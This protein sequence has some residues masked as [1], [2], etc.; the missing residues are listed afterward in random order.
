MNKNM[1]HRKQKLSPS[2]KV[3]R[4]DD[5]ERYLCAQFAPRKFRDAL[6]TLLAFNQE[7]GRIPELVSEPALGQ[8]RLQWWCDAVEGIY[9]GRIAD[10]PVVQSLAAVVRGHDLP[11]ALFDVYLEARSMDVERRIPDTLEELERYALQTSGAITRLQVYVLGG[12]GAAVQDVAQNVGCAWGLIGLMR[13][14]PFHGSQ[15]RDYRPTALDPAHVVE[16]IVRR[17][18]ELIADARRHRGEVPKG[19][20]SALLPCLF[21]DS[22]IKRLQRADFDPYALDETKPRPGASLRMMLHGVIGRY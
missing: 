15:D 13:A 5:R 17:A 20:V 21:A 3:A 16:I 19:C 12:Q 7:V 6:Y 2:A 9:D 1:P 4:D 14:V 11:K 8:M 18:G 22:H 10:H